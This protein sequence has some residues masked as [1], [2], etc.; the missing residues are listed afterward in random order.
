M[1]RFVFKNGRFFQRKIYTQ[2]ITFQI[3]KDKQ[4]KKK[5]G[6]EEILERLYKHEI[7]LY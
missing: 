4:L 3:F 1:E 5:G 6:G 2:M 7:R